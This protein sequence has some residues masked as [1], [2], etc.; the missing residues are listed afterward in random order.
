MWANTIWGFWT[1]A[2]S[3]VLAMLGLDPSWQPV[4]SRAA[5][6]FF[7]LGIMVLGWP[8]AKAVIARLT[9]RKVMAHEKALQSLYAKGVAEWGAI[10]ESSSYSPDREHQK[11]VDWINTVSPLLEKLHV[12]M[13]LRAR[14]RTLDQF[15]PPK[16]SR[17][18]I[19]AYWRLHL[20]RLLEAMK[21]IGVKP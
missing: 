20:D 18:E 19:D 12:P 8:Y 17:N 7:V 3:C 21:V 2:A 16:G 14:F 9:S 4:L 11:L 10:H 5:V 13:L 1:L 6:L 15:D